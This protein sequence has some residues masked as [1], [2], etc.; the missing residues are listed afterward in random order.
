[1]DDYSLGSF[2]SYTT[3][4]S[5]HHMDDHILQRSHRTGLRHGPDPAV[6]PSYDATD[7]VAVG[8]TLKRSVSNVRSLEARWLVQNDSGNVADH[9]SLH[10]DRLVQEQ[11]FQKRYLF[12]QSHD[13][14]EE[15]VGCSH[16]RN[17]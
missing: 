17:C 1:M 6:G 13:P 11:T 7:L 5:Q 16:H 15:V 14:G 9:H 12:E 2:D 10:T 4:K 8:W 3:N